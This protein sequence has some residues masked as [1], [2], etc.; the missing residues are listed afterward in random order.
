VIR[1][2]PSDG[3]LITPTNNREDEKSINSN[4]GS[5]ISR[6]FIFRFEYINQYQNIP[7]KATT[8]HS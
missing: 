8:L 2:I 4:H 3:L 7:S 6:S 5:C 1:K